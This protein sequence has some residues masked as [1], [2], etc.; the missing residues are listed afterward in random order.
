MNGP[1][2]PALAGALL[3]ATGDAFVLTDD[4][5]R[6]LRGNDA[7]SALFQRDI[8]QMAGEDVGVLIPKH[9]HAGAPDAARLWDGRTAP[10][11]AHEI[12]GLRADGSSVPLLLRTGRVKTA[13]GPVSLLILRDQSTRRAL[14]EAVAR[15]ERMDAIGRMTGGISHDFNNLLT[16]IIGNLEL[17]D[18]ADLNDRH[19]KFLRDALSAAELGADLTSRLN[20]LSRKT[21]AR[22]EPVDMNQQ[23]EQAVGLLRHTIGSHCAVKSRLQRQVWPAAVDEAQLQTA[24]LNLA[25]NSQDAMP[26][27]GTITIEADN[28]DIDDSYVAQELGVDAGRYVRLSVSD[29]GHGMNDKDRNLALEPFFT[30][31]PVGHGTGLGLSMVYGFVKRSGGH[32]TLYSEP[33]AGTVVALYFP[34][35][36]PGTEI[37]R[38][39]AD[40]ARS[41]RGAPDGRVILVVEDN[42]K[43][44]ALTKSRLTALGFACQDVATAD[45]AWEM[46]ANGA[47]FDLVLTDIVM[48]GTMT[49][50]DLAQRIAQDRPDIAVLL[51]S[52][53]SE[54]VLGNRSAGADLPILH[55]PYRQADLERAIY[56]VFGK[57]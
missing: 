29:T 18:R 1:D 56:A 49:G 16:V 51:T 31:K 21:E 6:I 55:K 15:S 24:I 54:T 28:I 11:T 34:A 30:T 41:G 39:E 43:L 13:S 23:I 8:N 20:V 35:L 4:G 42:A 25:M 38:A 40:G 19:R 2:D 53:F 9:P 26:D 52:G 5:G 44:R 14:Q 3:E 36:A 50:F 7:A 47:A 57:G 32:L 17:L 10:G 45:E 37:P 22:A 27:G 48:P 33:G 46:L 12:T